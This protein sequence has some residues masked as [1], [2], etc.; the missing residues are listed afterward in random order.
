MCKIT[1]P[2]QSVIKFDADQKPIRGVRTLAE[3][4][5][6]V[7][8]IPYMSREGLGFNESRLW[9]SPDF[10]STIKVGSDDDH[11]LLMASI[12]RTCKLE[13]YEKYKEFEN[14]ERSKLRSRNH[15]D[16]ELLKVTGN[17]GGGGGDDKD[18]ATPEITK[19]PEE[20]GEAPEETKG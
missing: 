5:H 10:T 11:A 17:G 13:T 8:C 20:T 4:A 9:T 19:T 12:F 1:N 2:D 7:R 3:I 14:T 16:E 6:Y 15:E 18:D